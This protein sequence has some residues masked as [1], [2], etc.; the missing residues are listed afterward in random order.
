MRAGSD[1]FLRGPVIHVMSNPWPA[2]TAAEG[3]RQD[4]FFGF[5]FFTADFLATFLAL[6]FTLPM[7]ALAAW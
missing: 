7:S 5:A 3:S 4:H 1:W 6:L 2:S